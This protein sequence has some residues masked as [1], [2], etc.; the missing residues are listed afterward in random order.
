MYT[1]EFL[2]AKRLSGDDPADQFVEHVFSNPASKAQLQQ[3]MRSP[4]RPG[5]LAEMFPGVAMIQEAAALPAWSDAYLMGQGA[6]FFARHSEM[7]MNLLGLL[8]LPYCYTAANGAMVLHLSNK[9][10]NHTTQRLFDTAIFVWQVMSPD[11]F[12]PTGTGF[13]E[14]LK[15]RI[16]H[17]T[18]RYYTK[19]SGKWDY[20]WG[21]PVNQEDMAGTNLSFSFIVIRG[22]RLLGFKVSAEEQAAFMHIWAVIG[23]LSG[24]H[25]DLIPENATQAE[26]LDTMIK[27]RQF[28]MSEH[29]QELTKSLIDHI[30]KVNNS[31]ASAGDI[32][33]L[34]RY[35][36]G[37]ELSGMLNIGVPRLRRYKLFLLRATHY[38]KSFRS[39]GDYRKEYTL[40]Y[41]KFK[42]QT[43]SFHTSNHLLAVHPEP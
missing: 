30:L 2:A 7:I 15:I 12:I 31:A 20:S 27:R 24:L 25:Q 18:V 23:Y 43:A 33:G 14:I 4:A 41:A 35:L 10:R 11:A 37:E 3:W 28:R 34:M 16:I 17:A 32:I 38:V 21:L 26:Q 40:G 8:S 1:N 36:L 22:L 6:A 29:G 39:I 13:E 5:S 19:L 9:I 42:S